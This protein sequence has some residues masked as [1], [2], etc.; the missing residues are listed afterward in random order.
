MLVD[1]YTYVHVYEFLYNI[2]TDTCLSHMYMS[3]S[4]I[5]LQ[6]L[7]FSY[8]Y[9]SFSMISL[10]TLVFSY[11][12][13]SFSMISLQTLVF[14]TCIWVSLWYHYRHLSFCTCL[15]VSLWYHYRHLSFPHVYE[16]L[17]NIITDTCLFLHGGYHKQVNCHIILL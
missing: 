7:V 11:M 17:Y 3:F 1:P 14:P 16:F 5:S 15:W 4:M 9:M 6:T 2:I 13:M 8:I 12:Y 10:Q